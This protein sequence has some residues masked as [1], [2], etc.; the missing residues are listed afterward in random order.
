MEGLANYISYE[1]F[2]SLRLLRDKILIENLVRPT[3]QGIIGIKNVSLMVG[4]CTLCH[5]WPHG[6][7]QDK[8]RKMRARDMNVLSL[9]GMDESG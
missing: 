6:V 4:G 3:G 8:R 7:T 9:G 5:V 2:G 1:A